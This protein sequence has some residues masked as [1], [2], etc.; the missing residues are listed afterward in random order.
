MDRNFG[1]AEAGSLKDPFSAGSAKTPGLYSGSSI[2]RRD[3]AVHAF[4]TL[5]ENAETLKGAK[6]ALDF[7]RPDGIG[8]QL[9]DTYR[10]FGGCVRRMRF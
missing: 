1:G 10:P 4:Q 2:A 6:N 5:F 7:E 3:L 9:S 8:N